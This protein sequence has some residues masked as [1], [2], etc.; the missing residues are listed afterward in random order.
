MEALQN[1][2]NSLQDRISDLEKKIE[3]PKYALRGTFKDP[4]DTKIIQHST[5]KANTGSI[6]LGNDSKI[7]SEIKEVGETNS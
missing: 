3:N 7:N 1:Q 4:D 5:L 6:S 2:V